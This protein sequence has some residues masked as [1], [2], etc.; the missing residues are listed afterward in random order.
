MRTRRKW[1][2]L[3]LSCIV[4]A[5]LIFTLFGEREPQYEGKS[6][7]RWANVVAYGP[8]RSEM[9]EAENAVRKIGTN[10]LPYLLKWIQHQDH[11]W[12][13]NLARL[14]RKLPGKL[15][16]TA[17]DFIILRHRRRQS[18]AFNA[19]YALGPLA[20]PA[21]PILTR[22]LTN[23][24]P[25]EPISVLAHI[26]D[27][28][29]PS[30]LN[31]VT[32]SAEPSRPRERLIIHLGRSWKEFTQ[33]NIIES[34]LDGCLDD[35]DPQVAVNAAEVLCSQTLNRE[36]ALQVLARALESSDGHLRSSAASAT[37]RCFTLNP[38][39]SKLTQFL[40]D[41]NSPFSPYAATALIG[42]V[43]KD[44]SLRPSAVPVLTRSLSDPR[45]LV[46]ANC[47]RT[48]GSLREATEPTVTA[49]LGAWNDLDESV[50]REATNSIFE[51][52]S[53]YYLRPFLY[54]PPIEM[55]Q[56]NAD[57]YASRLSTPPYS[58][59]LTQL[60]AHPDIRFRQMATNAFRML[61][62]STV[63]NQT[64]QNASRQP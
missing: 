36:R 39:V 24:F 31:V 22:Q 52:P 29:L 18:G 7:S 13:T 16:Q 46:R 63:F 56:K 53:Y 26:G 8:S 10:G 45:P 60:L 32:N 11:P 17:E 58:T 35:K 49:L 30:I 37:F 12:Q 43:A 6:L 42:A 44:P 57:Y 21:I 9:R 54:W 61:S 3:L 47:A 38:P 41:T 20:K 4:A 34:N 28:A 23:P 14:C 48:L 2:W 1:L 62:N 55:P 25:D 59:A 50:R 5:V 64:S 40:A 51:L 19:L 33:T 27:A 15:G